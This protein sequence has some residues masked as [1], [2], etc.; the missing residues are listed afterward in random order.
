MQATSP[1]FY[2]T[3]T[4]NGSIVCAP[5]TGR[6]IDIYSDGATIYG[7]GLNDFEYCVFGGA[8]SSLTYRVAREGAIDL[9]GDVV[10]RAGTPGI[11]LPAGATLAIGAHNLTLSAAGALLVDGAPLSGG[12]GASG[13]AAI[14][15]GTID[16]AAIGGTTPAPGT[17]STLAS[18]TNVV[19]GG[20]A[21][22]ATPA[23]YLNAAAGQVKQ[24]V[25]QSG[26]SIRWTIGS[27][28]AAETG[29]NAGS[30]FAFARWDDA[31]NW[32][33]NAIAITR[34]TGAVLIPNADV[35]GGT[36]DATPIGGTIP[37]A[38]RFTTLAATASLTAKFVLAAPNAANGAPVWRQLLASDISGLGTFATA[39]TAT[40]PT[41]G[42]TTP[43]PGT[44][45]TLTH[46][47]F[48]LR[49]MA[50]GL[51]ASTTN[52]QAGALGL[53]ASVNIVTTAATNSAVRLPNA[54][55]ATGTAAEI[56]VRNNGA[57]AMNCFP[58]T[59]GIINSLAA[60][61]AISIPAGTAMRFVQTSATQYYTV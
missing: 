21:L 9:A 33:G 7:F 46:T 29:S 30:D 15:G 10:F 57:N 24:F 34:A 54:A 11:Q 61:A 5:T 32:L 52:T 4:L 41:I 26:G 13:T 20:S 23:M 56:M 25:F 2:G 55:P 58:P 19:I 48:L 42:N 59:N 8:G 45:T 31:G 22:A 6:K 50:T 1:T 47:G 39:N 36:I 28:N 51:T 43:A 53:T 49:S 38:G 44:F 12:G 27:N 37:A 17:F 3:V 18:A 40:P 16:N 14:T 35:E 60:N